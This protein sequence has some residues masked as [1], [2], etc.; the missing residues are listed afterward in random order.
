M[1]TYPALEDCSYRSLHL[2]VYLI[3]S[4]QSCGFL[5]GGLQSS[6]LYH[7]FSPP[8]HVFAESLRIEGAL[9]IHYC[10][11]GFTVRAHCTY[12]VGIGGL[13][14]KNSFSGKSIAWVKFHGFST[15]YYYL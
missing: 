14:F 10:K 5:Q 9:Q 15:D 4:L 13:I 3:P 12:P 8:P 7:F 6:W 11:N 2:N 1:P